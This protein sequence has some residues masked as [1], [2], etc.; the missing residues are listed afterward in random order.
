MVR[1]IAFFLSIMIIGFA[2]GYGGYNM[3]SAKHHH[4]IPGI[5]IPFDSAAYYSPTALDYA[6]SPSTFALRDL[7]RNGGNVFDYARYLKNTLATK[8]IIDWL[9]IAI[10]KTGIDILNSTPF[11]KGHLE[12]TDEDIYKM[13]ALAVDNSLTDHVAKLL[14]GH[15]FR[16]VDDLYDD[17]TYPFDSKTRYEAV[18]QMTTDMIQTSQNFTASRDEQYRTY[19]RI[20]DD[21]TNAAG[22]MQVQQAQA[23]AEAF[24]QA[25]Q[26]QRNALLGNL[27]AVK[28]LQHKIEE[29]E[30]LAFQRSSD[31]NMLHF[32]DPFHRSPVEQ[33]EYESTNPTPP[34][35]FA[36]FK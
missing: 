3:A 31:A 36:A 18:Q 10:Q 35:G 12:K 4:P 14:T 29:D 24:A 6:D 9:T 25:Q 7:A 20:M 5:D 13:N 8:N 16:S 21:I 1:K 2:V 33:K 11:S 22:E 15:T 23:E 30:Q 27:T 26:A 28:Q 32:P 34:K 19:Q 17:D